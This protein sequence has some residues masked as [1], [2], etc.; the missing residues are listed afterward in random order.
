[1]TESGASADQG[2]IIASY[3]RDECGGDPCQ[4]TMAFG[5][6][7]DIQYCQAAS[8]DQSVC[9]NNGDIYGGASGAEY[10]DPSGAS[11]RAEREPLGVRFLT[12]SGMT[13]IL[14]MCSF[15]YAECWGR[16]D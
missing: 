3:T 8:G 1:M 14:R 9:Q 12:E 10:P 6:A 15:R 5:N 16:V 4:F 11:K 7:D 13:I 2:G